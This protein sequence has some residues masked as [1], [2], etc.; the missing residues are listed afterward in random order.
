[1]GAVTIHVSRLETLFWTLSN[2]CSTDSAVPAFGKA[3]RVVCL[4]RCVIFRIVVGHGLGNHHLHAY[5]FSSRASLHLFLMLR[6]KLLTPTPVKEQTNPTRSSP[7]DQLHAC[8]TGVELLPPPILLRDALSQVH[9]AVNVAMMLDSI[10]CELQC[11]FT[12]H[13]ATLR[14]VAQWRRSFLTAKKPEA[15]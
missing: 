5:S 15:L 3:P 6:Y 14:L 1:M 9:A 4:D 2:E 8:G 7:S 11:R 10:A 12:I 13:A